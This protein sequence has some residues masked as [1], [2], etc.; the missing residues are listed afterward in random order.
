MEVSRRRLALGCLFALPSLVCAFLYLLYVGMYSLGGDPHSMVM[1]P[2]GQAYIADPGPWGFDLLPFPNSGSCVWVVDTQHDRLSELIIAP[3]RVN[4]IGVAANG[5]VYQAYTNRG[6]GRRSATLQPNMPSC[7]ATLALALTNGHILFPGMVI[8]STTDQIM[9]R[10][11]MPDSRCYG[12]IAVSNQEAYVLFLTRIV[13]LSLNSY[14]ILGYIEIPVAAQAIVA[15]KEDG[16]AYLVGTNSGGRKLLVIDTRLHQV[17][18]EIAIPSGRYDELVGL[19]LTPDGKLY[20]L[21]V[22]G[23]YCRIIVISQRSRQVLGE[24]RLPDEQGSV[25]G[26]Y[27]RYR[28]AAAP[29]GRVYVLHGADGFT[30]AFW[31]NPEIYVVVIDPQKDEIVGKIPLQRP[32]WAKLWPF[33][34]AWGCIILVCLSPGL[35]AF[36][37]LVVLLG[38]VAIRSIRSNR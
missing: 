7:N 27:Y 31:D 20:L 35:F 13:R 14:E 3:E 1:G 29:N 34:G 26:E 32:L 8:D 30:S 6:F 16:L 38:D 11:V 15:S 4:E 22:S 18:D 2:N 10:I 28:I 5:R 9:K 37:L 33:E 12:M 24:I 17:V 19:C 21:K 23:V 36:V 25:N